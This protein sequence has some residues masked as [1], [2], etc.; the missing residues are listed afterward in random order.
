MSD[1][2]SLALANLLID[3]TKLGVEVH[4]LDPNICLRAEL[5]VVIHK[6]IT[7]LLRG[8]IV[9][10]VLLILLIHANLCFPF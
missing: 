3:R 5:D 4:S 6:L 9:F 8:I 7:G 1:I 2:S 10:Y